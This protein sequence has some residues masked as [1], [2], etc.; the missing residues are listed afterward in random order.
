MKKLTILCMIAA[1]LMTNAAQAQPTNKPAPIA[2]ASN[3]DFCWGIGLVGLAV[4]ST[5]VGLTA[6]S[7]S[8]GPNSYSNH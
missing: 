2:N 3:D 6:A 4:L 5:V 1:S 7:A 8:S